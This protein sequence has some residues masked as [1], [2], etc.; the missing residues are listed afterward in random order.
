MFL[1]NIQSD[2]ELEQKRLQ[3]RGF[4][5]GLGGLVNTAPAV[6]GFHDGRGLPPMIQQ[7]PMDQMRYRKL[8][9]IP[10]LTGVTKDE[11]KRAVH[12]KKK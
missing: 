5:S 10:L 6:E 8:P 1:H 11:T 2:S 9:K 7:P 3:S 12:S 4:V